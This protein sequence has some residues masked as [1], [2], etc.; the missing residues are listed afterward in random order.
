MGELI[1]KRARLWIADEYG[2]W[3]EICG[4]GEPLFIGLDLARDVEV[5]SPP[6]PKELGIALPPQRFWQDTPRTASDLRR[7][8]RRR[9]KMGPGA[10][11]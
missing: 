9:G 8:E 7:S 11:R 10:R 2:G 4:L 3:T 1:G 5:P 6:M